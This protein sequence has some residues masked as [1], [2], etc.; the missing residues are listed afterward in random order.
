ML[1]S[2]KRYHWQSVIIG[3]RDSLSKALEI[4]DAGA[5]RIALVVEDGKLSGVVTDGDIRRSL[6]KHQSLDTPVNQVM[7]TTPLVAYENQDQKN[8]LSKMVKRRLEHI[9]ILNSNDEL[10]GLETLLQMVE[11]PRYENPVL[12]MAGGF[13]TRL[14]P[15]TENT[16]KPL[17]NVGS[18]PILESIMESFIDAGFY[19]FYISLFYKA[20]MIRDYFGDGSK[21]GVEISYIEET[22]PLGTAGCI[23]LIQETIDLPL[24]LMNGDIL[25]KVDFASLLDFHNQESAHATLC[26]RDY[27]YQ[28]PYGVVEAMDNQLA[29][30]AEKPVQHFFVSAGIYVLS[31]SFI[32]EI[33]S[34]YQDVPDLLQ[35]SAEQKKKVSLYP[36]HEYW[37][38]IGRTDDF[39]QAQTDYKRHFSS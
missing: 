14:R 17:L 11:K 18:K 26:V 30:I 28:V 2:S 37:L 9:P 6:L 5:L 35:A 16:P 13:G 22:E 10:V 12:L 39:N 7:N 4:I 20:Q 25:T 19:K 21:W 34:G 15:L 31:S 27:E 36:I 8:L 33:P 38:D 29:N 3:P 32:K 24:I 1:T 23:N